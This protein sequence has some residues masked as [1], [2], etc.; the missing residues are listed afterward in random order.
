MASA[1]LGL[2]SRG[3]GA[4][5]EMLQGKVGGAVE[6]PGLPMPEFFSD[7][8]RCFCG[9]K[10]V[11][12]LG[13]QTRRS[14]N[15][16]E[17]FAWAFFLEKMPENRWFFMVFLNPIGGFFPWVFFPIAAKPV[18]AR[19]SLLRM[20]RLRW[21]RDGAWRPRPTRPVCILA[22][23]APHWLSKTKARARSRG[24]HGIVANT[25]KEVSVA[26]H[27]RSESMLPMEPQ[28]LVGGEIARRQSPSS[29]SKSPAG[30]PS[31]VAPS[32]SHLELLVMLTSSRSTTPIGLLV[33]G[34]LLAVTD[35]GLIQERGY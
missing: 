20:D 4:M 2:A 28:D 14:K 18:L 32:V 13:F 26:A 12:C 19:T 30:W 31:T 34:P 8:K 3:A 5:G 10:S 1:R 22:D 25:E 7:R 17:M 33:L 21:L 24:R 23:R 6:T 9:E 29:S 35:S 15:S 27:G 11:E 16:R